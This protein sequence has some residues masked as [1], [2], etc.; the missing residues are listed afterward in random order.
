MNIPITK[1]AE[2]LSLAKHSNLSQREIAELYNVSRKTVSL[3]LKRYRETGEVRDNR[4]GRSGRK[5]KIDQEARQLL[6]EESFRDPSKTS[7]DLK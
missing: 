7:I 3:I 6:F 1:R 5:S 4:K 2:I